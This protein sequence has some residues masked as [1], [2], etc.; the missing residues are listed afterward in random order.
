M[1]FLVEKDDYSP[2]QDVSISSILLIHSHLLMHLIDTLIA[3]KRRKLNGVHIDVNR[4]CTTSGVI[5]V[6]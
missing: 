2:D 6:N 1:V 4:M 3:A 5:L